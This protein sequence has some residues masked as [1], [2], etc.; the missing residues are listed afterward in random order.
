MKLNAKGKLPDASIPS[1]FF[2]RHE[3]VKLRRL[4]AH[5]AI[6]PH[7][8]MGAGGPREEEHQEEACS[9][10]CIYCTNRDVECDEHHLVWDCPNFNEERTKALDV[11]DQQLRPTSFEAWCR[12]EGERNKR[13]AVLSGLLNYLSETWLDM[14]I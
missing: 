6:T 8:A 4:R 13:V 9:K 12:P 2:R 10:G 11:L 14:H 3:T 7:P 5:T 1:G